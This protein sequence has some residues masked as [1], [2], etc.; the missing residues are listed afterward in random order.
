LVVCCGLVSLEEYGESGVSIESL[1]AK[2][3]EMVAMDHFLILILNF[4]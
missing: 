1:R 4:F 3:L 2:E